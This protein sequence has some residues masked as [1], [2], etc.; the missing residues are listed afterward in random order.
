MKTIL[1]YAYFVILKLGRNC[2]MPNINRRRDIWVSNKKFNNSKEI[3]NPSIRIGQ[4]GLK[5][6]I[7]DP[8]ITIKIHN[9]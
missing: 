8:N 1:I 7:R 9:K 6:E 5:G 3:K 4:R 2:Y